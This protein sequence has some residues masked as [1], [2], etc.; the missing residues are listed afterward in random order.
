MKF[1]VHYFHYTF[2]YFIIVFGFWTTLFSNV[3][4]HIMIGMA[5]NTRGEAMKLWC[6]AA[7]V[8]VAMCVLVCDCVAVVCIDREVSPS[9]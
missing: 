8:F 5:A 6:A 7:L 3:Q 9:P 4:I 1:A 2:H